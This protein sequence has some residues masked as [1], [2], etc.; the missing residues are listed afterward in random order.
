MKH[1]LFFNTSKELIF[2]LDVFFFVICSITENAYDLYPASS[3]FSSC[4]ISRSFVHNSPHKRVDIVGLHS[5]CVD[6]HGK[7]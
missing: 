6:A 4:L 1:K 7:C 5:C 2:D 3:D